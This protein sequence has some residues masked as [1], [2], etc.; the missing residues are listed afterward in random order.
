[1][2]IHDLID[3]TKIELQSHEFGTHTPLGTAYTVEQVERA[4]F[5]AWYRIATK[6]ILEE[7]NV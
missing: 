7:G 4:V 1:M 3:Q 6:E 5:D 2:K